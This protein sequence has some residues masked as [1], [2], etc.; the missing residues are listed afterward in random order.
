MVGT[1]T[2]RAILAEQQRLGL[3]PQDGRAGIKILKALQ[4]DMPD[5]TAPATRPPGKT[6]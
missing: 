2:R 6:R 4:A 5:A 3:Q 1:L